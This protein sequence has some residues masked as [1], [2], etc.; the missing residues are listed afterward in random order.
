[1]ALRAIS[2]LQDAVDLAKQFQCKL[3]VLTP[4]SSMQLKEL[5]QNGR[6]AAD[7]YHAASDQFFVAWV[8]SLKISMVFY[9]DHLAPKD[10]KRGLAAQNTSKPVT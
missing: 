1:M 6:H 5:E 10:L 4:A 9:S 7:L 2:F 3:G 8:M